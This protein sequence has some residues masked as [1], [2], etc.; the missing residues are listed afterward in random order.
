MK[1]ECEIYDIIDKR[2]LSRTEFESA[3]EIKL[4]WE[5]IAGKT[6]Y[7]KDRYIL[8]KNMRLLYTIIDIESRQEFECVSLNSL[9]LHLGF[10]LNRNELAKISNIKNHKLYSC[11][12][13]GRSFCLKNADTQKIKKYLKEKEP[14]E[15]EKSVRFKKYRK[16]NLEKEKLRSKLWRQKNK[17]HIKDYNKNYTRKRYQ[18][19]PEFRIRLNLR[20]RINQAIKKS[21]SKR[22]FKLE[23][24]IGCT[25]QELKDHLESQ[26]SEGMTWDNQGQ[27]HIDHIKPCVT[28]DLTKKQ[29]QLDCCNYKNLQPLWAE[30]NLKK[31]SS[32]NNNT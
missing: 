31:G 15:S 19:D 9:G 7:F 32:F 5:F 22:L 8:S 18:S 10:K 11:K 1:I 6:K 17:E 13:R 12:I 23:K 16:K 25:I 27:W 3:N 14:S 4:P 2:F 29:D 30:E 20:S 28:F 26:F 24:L 21:N